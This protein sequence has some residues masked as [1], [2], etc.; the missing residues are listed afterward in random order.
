MNSSSSRSSTLQNCNRGYHFIFSGAAINSS[1]P[2]QYL[3]NSLDKNGLIQQQLFAWKSFEVRNPKGGRKGFQ[4][5][6]SITETIYGVSWHFERGSSQ[7]YLP[8]IAGQGELANFKSGFG[9]ILEMTTAYYYRYCKYE[10]GQLVTFQD[11]VVSKNRRKI[12]LQENR[13][14]HDCPNNPFRKRQQQLARVRSYNG[15]GTKIYV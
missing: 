5:A 7:D 13:L 3:S 14:P 1:L 15:E 10:C 11:N 2:Y 4:S 12:P 6:S 8:E 9:G